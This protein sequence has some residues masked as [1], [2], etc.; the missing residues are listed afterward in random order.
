MRLCFPYGT[1]GLSGHRVSQVPFHPHRASEIPRDLAPGE[2]AA[3]FSGRVDPGSRTCSS[4]VSTWGLACSHVRTWRPRTG[5]LNCAMALQVHAQFAIR[6]PALRTAGPQPARMEAAP[7]KQAM[8]TASHARHS[9]GGAGKIF[10]ARPRGP[11]VGKIHRSSV[12]V[13]SPCLSS[14]DSLALTGWM[15]N[16]RS[17]HRSGFGEQA[18]LSECAGRRQCAVFPGNPSW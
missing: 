13:N 3:L 11:C 1:S 6:A 12:G 10:C 5:I 18:S 17:S 4:E 2:L 14:V 7:A 9:E 16:L 8:A 15:V